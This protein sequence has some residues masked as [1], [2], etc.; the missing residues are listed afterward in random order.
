MKPRHIPVIT[1]ASILIAITASPLAA[2]SVWN[3]SDGDY[4]DP[5]NWTP[6]AD[7][8]GGDEV[9][10]SSGTAT[11]PSGNLERAADTTLNG[12]NLVIA[13]GRF[14]NNRPASDTTFTVEAGSSLTQTGNYFIVAQ[15]AGLANF[16]Q[17]GGTV[18]SNVD[19][20]WGLSD[21][22]STSGRYIMTGG[23]LDVNLSGP[24][25]NWEAVVGRAPGGAGDLLEIG[26]G[27]T[28]NFAADE[29]STNRRF[30]VSNRGVVRVLAG[31]QLN[32]ADLRFFVVGRAAGSGMIPLMHVDGGALNVTDTDALIVS[33]NGIFQLDDG[34]VTVSNTG[35]WIAD[36]GN[37]GAAATVLHNGGSLVS[38]DQPISLSHASTRSGQYFMRGGTLDVPDIIVGSG[39]NPKFFYE[40]GTVKLAG[41]RTGIVDEPFF[42]SHGDVTATYDGDTNT[43]TLSVTPS[44]GFEY[45]YQY[46]RFTATELRSG[47]ATG[48]IQLAE[49]ELLSGGA[50]VDLSGATVINPGGDNPDGQT[51]AELIDGDITTKWLDFNNAPVVID[52][53]VTTAVDGYRLTTGNDVPG[54]DPVRWTIEGSADGSTWDLIERV[55]DSETLP[56]G[57]NVTSIGIPLREDVAIPV[58]T[59]TGNASGD[60]DTGALNWDEAGARTWANTTPAITAIFGNTSQKSI[61]ITED[62]AAGELRFD[63]AGYEIGGVGTLTLAP[64]AAVHVSGETLISAPLAGSSGMLKTGEATL[65]LAGNNTLSGSTRI[66]SG[67]LAI[68]GGGTIGSTLEV[69]TNAN[70]RATVVIDSPGPH[71]FPG[72]LRLGG[73]ADAQ[74]ALVIKSG[75]V[76]TGGGNAYIEIGG[77]FAP[78]D[79]SWGGLRVEG[80]SLFTELTP[81]AQTSGIR[82]GGNG[83]GVLTQ[84]GGIINSRRWFAI[85]RPGGLAG[86]GVVSLLGGTTIVNP[87]FRI[88]LGDSP[89]SYGTLN[90]GTLDGGDAEVTHLNA[91]G[92]T[93]GS[94]NSASSA[95][96]NLNRGTLTLGGP[97]YKNPASSANATVN[98]NGALL[99]AGADGISLADGSLSS[100]F[101]HNGGLTVDTN[102]NNASFGAN[103]D[104]PQ[105]QGVR[106]AAGR[107]EVADGGA[108]YLGEPLVRVT[109]DGFGTGLS[110]IALVEGGEVSGVIITCPGRNYE[111]GDALTF[112][113]IGGG[114][115]TP[116]PFSV[117]V[118]T[119]DDLA[120]N[121]GGAFVKTGEGT[122]E[123]QGN[124]NYDGDTIVGQGVLAAN[125]F[126]GNTLLTVNT[127]AT[128][129]GNLDTFGP[130]LL[131][132]TLAP[133]AGVGT[134]RGFDK[135]TI[136][137]GSTLEIDLANWGDL[138]GVDHDTMVF[139]DIDI[140][141]TSSGKFTL[142]IVASG[143][144]GFSETDRSFLIADTFGVTGFAA[145][146]WQLDV[147][148]FPGSG[149]WDFA[150][151]EGKLILSYTG[152]P[153]AGTDFDVWLAGFPGLSDPAPLADP[154]KD[155][156]ANVLEYI[157][158]GNPTVPG[159]ATL[160]VAEALPNGDLVFSF[161]RR[162]ASKTTTTQTFQYGTD[163]TGWTDVLVPATSAG[164]VVI[165]ADTPAA[166]QE[167]VTL[168]IDAANAPSGRIFGRLQATVN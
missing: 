107:F 155:G 98:F 34:T 104:T 4:N 114:A 12:G 27:A 109:T 122:L 44:S 112:D 75:E 48:T 157:L 66:E 16:I 52:F 42:V 46:Y 1:A 55:I 59:W 29:A 77:G 17:N 61:N 35:I 10:I 117:H 80:G 121:A 151:D 51:P 63:E 72:S 24:D 85:G 167:T 26:N 79:N 110:A 65:S 147:V 89:G 33:N 6:E 67:T 162:A 113:F 139:G 136:E 23:T 148:G 19:R 142:R 134:A 96:L 39:L 22:G 69:A 74:G 43:T 49:L 152:D 127:G 128:L 108:G 87:N 2:Q 129:T 165:A 90:L 105:G 143:L 84:T 125:G 37:T 13:N 47:G 14:L 95:V 56:T 131:E 144:A 28:A 91:T 76:L 8:V 103:L 153:S 31:G 68:T 159:T 15:Q 60:W 40:G 30:F 100:A 140:K 120:D 119:A 106:P 7:P 141:A 88:L 158:G 73:G 45:S 54:R 70:S 21:G 115:T 116:A 161:V 58:L 146:N 57:R 118:L 36:G 132:G 101:L 166:G 123:L 135:L 138:E 78:A 92:L 32:A 164:N 41:D 126:L 25:F 149:T 5:T 93:V 82:V 20:G 18:T 124:S 83:V 156:V 150:E 168:T 11:L 130:V 9:V 81:E 137:V 133:G 64:V 145:D 3:G 50:A 38:T 111:T 53:G 94:N 163:L 86:E 99:V 154:D 160:P 97:L 102:G 71:V 62:I